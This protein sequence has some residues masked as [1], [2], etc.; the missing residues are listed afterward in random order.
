MDLQLIQYPIFI[1]KKISPT[2]GRG[3]PAASPGLPLGQET[4][5]LLALFCLCAA[6]GI[7]KDRREPFNHLFS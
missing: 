6:C 5:C 4:L 3:L 1:L 7:A 2:I